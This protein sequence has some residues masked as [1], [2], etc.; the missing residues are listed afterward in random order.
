MI[1]AAVIFFTQLFE[2]LAEL[3]ADGFRYEILF[4]ESSKSV[5]VRRYKETRRRHPLK[6]STILE[7]IDKE[8]KILSEIRGKATNIIDTSFLSPNELRDKIISLYAANRREKACR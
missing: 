1:S 5:L 3:E 4:L 7:S 8:I 2:S 6:E